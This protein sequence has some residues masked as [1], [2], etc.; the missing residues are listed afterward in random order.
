M[1][2]A[3]TSGASS[4]GPIK[5]VLEIFTMVVLIIEMVM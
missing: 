2:L 4:E 1:V 3:T 5:L